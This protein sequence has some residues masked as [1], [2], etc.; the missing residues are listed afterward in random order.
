MAADWMDRALE[1]LLSGTPSVSGQPRSWPRDNATCN[2]T[3][4]AAGTTP[5]AVARAQFWLAG[6][7]LVDATLAEG[8]G[9]GSNVK[10]AQAGSASVTFFQPTIGS[11]KD[12][13]LPITA[14][15]YLRCF[16]SGAGIVSGAGVATGTDCDSAFGS[17]DFGRTSGF[18]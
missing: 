8:T 18:N 11:T 2:G 4:L 10:Q 16:F 17:S 15:D 14:M 13:R 7:L 9:T 3:A 1:G 6:K 5:D 12:T